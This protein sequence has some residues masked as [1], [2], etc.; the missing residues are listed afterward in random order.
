MPVNGNVRITQADGF[1]S[2]VLFDACSGTEIQCGTSDE[3]Y[4]DLVQNTTYVLKVASRNI[5]AGTGSFN[6][7]AFAP[8][9]N[10]LCADAITIPIETANAV[11]TAY[12][13]AGATETLQ[14]SCETASQV[15]QDL[16]YNFTMPVNGNVRIT[17]ANG[18]DSYV[19]F[20]ACS[21]TEIQCGTSDE[22]F[23]DLVQNTTYVLK[24]ASR[25]I[26][27]GAASFN[28]QAFVT[29]VNNDCSNALPIQVATIGE[30]ANEN[31]T[32][33]LRGA[34]ETLQGSCSSNSQDFLDAWYT[35]EAPLTGNISLNSNSSFNNFA[36]YDTCNGT[37]IVCFFNTGSIPVVFGQTYTLQVSRRDVY[38]DSITFCLEGA[39]V[40][41]TGTSGTCETLPDVTISSA[42][43]NTNEWVPILDS[44]GNIAAAINAN[45]NDLGVVSATLFIDVADTR[46]TSN[47]QPYSR[48][49]ISITPTNQPTTNVN[50]RIYSLEDEVTDLVIADSNL[51]NYFALDMMR[52][53]GS[54]CTT[55][56][57]MGGDFIN[58]STVFYGSDYYTGFSSNSFS[59]FYPTSTN[60]DSTLSVDTIDSILGV[61]IYPTI[62]SGIFNVKSENNLGKTMLSVLDLNGRVTL[63]SE[64]NIGSNPIQI[65]LE[66]A[67]KGFYFL[68]LVHNG[69]TKTQ[70]LIL[71]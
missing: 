54:G 24:V 16:W 29:I 21:G 51:N 31:N 26:Y 25:N 8:V 69:N 48:R 34:T 36:V 52:V 56:Y 70:K 57:T 62:S 44:S 63:F 20:D 68:K 14:G 7:Q 47:S 64:V 59:V 23:Y 4:Y 65:N 28:I 40:V 43:N 41:A 30:C 32:V 22:Y 37:E 66:N 2:Y 11:N 55:G 42:Q 6:I 12:N 27:A 5:Y 33:D 9:V 46:M 19:L 45:G 58:A 10:N 3:F 1:D 61:S 38:A 35:F 13:T 49:E 18:F 53:D 50:L 17:Q 71:K 39:P 60:L 67:S 15:W